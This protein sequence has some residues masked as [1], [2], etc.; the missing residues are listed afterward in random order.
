[1]RYPSP[2]RIQGGKVA[3]F[4]DAHLGQVDRDADDFLASLERLRD[5]GARTVVL[6]GDIFHY[7]IGDAKFETPLIRRV[8]EGWRHLTA[9]GVSLRYV[10]GNRDFFLAGTRFAASFAA[11]GETDGLEAG[12]RRYA[13]VHGDRVNTSDLPYR[14]WRLASKN[15]IAYGAMK[16][17]PGPL[18]RAIVAR[19]EARLYRTNFKHKATLPARQLLEEGRRA[20]SAGYDEL[21]VGHF[22]VERALEGDGASV[23]VLPAWLEERKHAEIAEDG[24]LSIVEEDTASRAR[25]RE[26][27]VLA[28]E[29]RA[30]AAG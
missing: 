11:Y 22:H 21:L 2:T 14:L 24:T 29:R 4:A 27:G 23:R 3:V 9:S 16:A 17:L 8:L 6:L 15:P 18:A 1:M 19:T 30:G 7:F 13:F 20:R 28:H 25:P 12:G 26:L 5:G 10:E